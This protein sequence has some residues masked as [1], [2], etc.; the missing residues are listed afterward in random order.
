MKTVLVTRPEPGGQSLCQAIDA[1]GGQSVYFPTM[2]I[3]PLNTQNKTINEC[4]IIIFTS[5]N[6]VIHANT[7]LDATKKA[8]VATV[9]AG[10]ANALKQHNIKTDLC[11][12]K[13]FN[14]EGLL[15]LPEMQAVQNKKIVIVKGIAGRPLLEET[16][17]ARGANLST[18]C[19]YERKLPVVEQKRLDELFN[20][21]DIDIIVCTSCECLENLF[22][23]ATNH[24]AA[25]RQQQLLVSSDRIA[26]LA[27]SLQ[28]QHKPILTLNAQ[29]ETIV[30]SLF[31]E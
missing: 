10:T 30:S 17:R 31:A 11:P 13:Q 5:P 12:D 7:L 24:V 28:F 26:R 22:I 2:E 15:E 21:T 20:R 23:L 19:V 27:T 18:V 6:A 3:H 25:L 9:G 1:A 14:S 8:A 16:L 4:D 29:N